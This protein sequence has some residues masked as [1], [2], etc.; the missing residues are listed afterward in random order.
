MNDIPMPTTPLGQFDSN[1]AFFRHSNKRPALDTPAN[2]FEEAINKWYEYQQLQAAVKDAMKAVDL[3]ERELRDGIAASLKAFFADNLK[4]G[5]NN[6]VMSNG[7]KL[8]YT[9]KVD[10]K[11]T[12]AELK[13]AREAYEAAAKEG[14]PTFDALLRLKYEL[15]KKEWDKAS[16][17][18]VKAFSRCMTTKDAAPALEVD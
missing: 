2:P 3:A 16:D 8:K 13:N 10:R 6:Y 4:E 18:A 11:I 12:E 5:T 9:H 17:D 7:R 15:A 1:L 14:D